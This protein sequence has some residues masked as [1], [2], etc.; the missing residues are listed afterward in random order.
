MTVTT[1]SYTGGIQSFVVAG[2]GAVNV[3][4]W[5]GGGGGGAYNA[6]GLSGAGGFTDITFPVTAGDTI[7]VDVGGGGFGAV[8]AVP[9]GALGGWP[10]GGFG[11]YGDTW[12][13]GGGGSSAVY[14]NGVLMAV[15]GG[16]GAGSGFTYQA[17]AG[18]GANGQDS[19]NSRQGGSQ[20]AG[21]AG[22]GAAAGSSLLG[23]N[24]GPGS[25]TT[26]TTDDGGGGGGG[27]FGG[28]G[29]MGDGGAGGGGS[30]YVNLT[31]G[32]IGT[33]TAGNRATPAGIANPGYPGAP[34]AV[35]GAPSSTAGGN[36]GNGV[37]LVDDSAVILDVDAHLTQA[38]VLG[39]VRHS[40]P[41]RLTQAPVL[42]LV[43]RQRPDC[44]TSDAL[45]WRIERSDGVVYRFTSHDRATP[46]NGEVYTPCK[47][48]SSSA[49][50]LSAELGKTD[51]VD[52]AGIISETGITTQDLWSGL[53]DGADVQV[54]EM[55][56]DTATSPRLI[57]DG[58]TGRLQFGDTGYKFEMTTAAERL[59]QRP[60]LRMVM[61]RCRFKL[62]DA[63]CGVDLAP[64]TIT[65]TVT[66]I[67]ARNIFTQLHRRAFVDSTKVQAADYWSLG[68]VT[69]TTGANAGLGVDVKSFEA[70]TFV[71]ERPLPYAVGIGDAYTVRPG[72]DLF[73]QTC[74]DKFAN[75]INFG[76][77]P[78][79]RGNDDMVKRPR[80]H[81][82]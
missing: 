73:L 14:R 77:F 27:Y 22:T 13:G 8:K 30:G 25:R 10:N 33:T 54:W 40:P 75:S 72:C 49:L 61:P 5:G 81:P 6:G 2:N 66:A 18:G 28:A 74:K 78:Y 82:V 21:G 39:L 46:L 32:V 69:F 7:R 52:L 47:S 4:L 38:P 42:V 26:S 48:L 37:V 36:G 62:G 59:T 65:G 1:Y 67:V 63:Q 45:F 55:A 56:W 23:G 79:M 15:A 64:L 29:G 71:L 70:G 68:R 41:A 58:Q 16:G 44:A 60:I 57:V 31:T 20:V 17:G 12:G 51:N 11:T 3:R 80:P 24:G 9:A 19:T 35:P 43:K 34:I 76:G 53:F 50:Q